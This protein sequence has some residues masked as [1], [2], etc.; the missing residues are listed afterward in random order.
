MKSIFSSVFFLACAALFFVSCEH[1]YLS[2]EQEEGEFESVWYIG[3]PDNPENSDPTGS[4][5][6]AASDYDFEVVP[7]N[8]RI[9]AIHRP[10]EP[11]AAN[12][13]II[14][15]GFNAADNAPGGAW[16]NKGRE[17]AREF[18]HAPVIRDFI[19][20]F[21]VYIFYADSPKTSSEAELAE[22]MAGGGG[23]GTPTVYKPSGRSGPRIHPDRGVVAALAKTCP[24]LTDAGGNLP[25]NYGIAF[26]SNSSHAQ[27]EASAGYSPR[28]EAWGY[29]DSNFQWMLHE[30]VGHGF[31]G[32]ADEYAAAAWGSWGDKGGNLNVS[33]H[34]FP[35]NYDIG[36]VNFPDVPGGPMAW[37]DAI[38]GDEK[39]D[40]YWDLAKPGNPIFDKDPS[41]AENLRGYFIKNSKWQSS[42]NP[43]KKWLHESEG[44]S[45]VWPDTDWK[46]WPA[47]VVF[48]G[49]KGYTYAEESSWW[50]LAPWINGMGGANKSYQAED[51]CTMRQTAYYFCVICRYRIWTSIQ[52]RAFGRSHDDL[53]IDNKFPSEAGLK[54]FVQFDRSTNYGR[55]DRTGWQDPGADM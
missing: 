10:K 25:A 42:M 22:I 20:N 46:H 2:E 21:G 52:E 38:F 1:K 48:I 32:V 39:G 5:I 31:A 12:I 55:Y 23:N 3:N 35:Q 41:I 37:A 43:N 36:Q 7:K 33:G 8:F 47:W 51:A 40:G 29:M 49:R 24:Y 18:I 45:S 17:L 44:K 50:R 27:W 26:I 30:Y 4:Y 16:D 9:V 53:Y 54:E 14:G 6:T 28:G 15:D 19:E 11:L 34:G 13:F